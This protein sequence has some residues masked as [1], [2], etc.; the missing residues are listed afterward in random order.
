MQRNHEKI[1]KRRINK[2]RRKKQIKRILTVTGVII[3]ALIINGFGGPAEIIEDAFL[4][5][6]VEELTQKGYP[7]SLSEL[8]V[9]NSET[10]K[11]VLGYKNY[12]GNTDD[13]DISGEIR[14]GK[15]PMFL[16][17]DERWG[18]EKYGDDFMALTGCGPTCLSMVYSGLTGDA[19][20]HP[21]KMAELAQ[22]QGYYV[23]GS[24]SSWNMMTGLAENV[25]LTVWKPSFTADS[26]K[27]E[28]QEGH[29]II[30]IMGPGDFT[31]AGHFIVLTGVMDGKIV[32]N[33][34]NSVKNSEKLWDIETIMRQTRDLWAYS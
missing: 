21:L 33:D 20:L 9:R 6:S 4:K 26:I 1:Q 32:V 8:Y 7:E 24:G 29:P 14:K 22:M 10:K 27:R 5:Y 2:R 15:I 31:T 16:Q 28:L 23:E 3:L 17:W 34:P 30:C 13:I 18:Y 25:G 19:S 12:D 11:F